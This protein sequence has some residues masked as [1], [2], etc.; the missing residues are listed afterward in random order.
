[1]E[2][3]FEQK[4]WS[5][6]N[7]SFR[8][9]KAKSD[10][11]TISQPLQQPTINVKKQFK[12]LA[13][14]KVERKEWT[15]S[16]LRD[17]FN[18]VNNNGSL[19]NDKPKYQ[20]PDVDGSSL[21][22]VTAN[23]WQ[24]SLIGDFLMEG[25]LQPI[26]LRKLENGTFEIVD[27]GHRCRS[28][29]KFFQGW[30]R[31]PKGTIITDENGIE[32]DLSGLNWK[33]IVSYGV[34]EN[35]DFIDFILTNYKLDIRIY[36]N[37]SNKE[38]E[39]LFIKLN[40]LNKMVDADFRN[41]KDHFVA[42]IVRELGSV[43]SPLA[44]EI[45]TKQDPKSTTPKLK[46]IVTP[47]TKRVTDTIVAFALHYLW[48]GGISNYKSVSKQT[49]YPYSGMDTEKILN[50]MYDVDGKDGSDIQSLILRLKDPNDTL[51][52]DLKKLLKIIDE[53]IKNGNLNNTNYGVWKAGAIKKLIMLVSE[54]A[55]ANG[56]FDKY[57][58]NTT[59][60][61]ESFQIAYREITSSKSTIKH[62]PHQFYKLVNDKIVVSKDKIKK[63][64]TG[65]T[66]SFSSVFVGGARVD[67]LFYIL[68]NFK[69]KGI[70]TFGLADSKDSNRTFSQN[71]SDEIVGTLST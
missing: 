63:V 65:K 59:Q 25:N 16:D 28:F 67:D 52:S 32:Y 53:I 38:A 71:Q 43:D 64:D 68:L 55:W 60:F 69:L 7:R 9:E 57:D 4:K 5:F 34:R 24:S 40:N 37:I 61:F 6:F 62:H 54:S 3:Q 35:I 33:D 47:I 17:K 26:Y 36:S 19:I 44:K 56:G 21:Q 30:L 18:P 1:M 8:R 13:I 49:H 11:S 58:P 48:K 66:F 46:Y 39:S 42:D 23:S 31:L 27:G 10:G 41:A 2:T 51:L 20:R 12:L 29:W 14:N 22:N 15:L 70:F 45:F 50:D